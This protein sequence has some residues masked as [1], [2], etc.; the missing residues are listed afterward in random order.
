M[1]D[2]KIETVTPTH[3]CMKNMSSLSSPKL[4]KVTSDIRS[5]LNETNQKNIPTM[6]QPQRSS[7]FGKNSVSDSSLNDGFARL[8]DNVSVGTSPDFIDPLLGDEEK[9]KQAVI[10][11]NVALEKITIHQILEFRQAEE[12]PSP[13]VEHLCLA[14]MQMI[15]QID[16]TVESPVK[17]WA[18]IRKIFHKPGHFVNSLR[19]FQ[20][21][22]DAGRVTTKNRAIPELESFDPEIGRV[23]P[24]AGYLRKWFFGAVGY[25]DATP[26]A[27]A[28]VPKTSVPERQA[29]PKAGRPTSGIPK[30]SVE[31]SSG[32]AVGS[33][34]RPKASC[35][36]GHDDT[37]DA[38]SASDIG[39]KPVR[40]VGSSLGSGYGQNRPNSA[41]APARV[42]PGSS[43]NASSMK[44]KYLESAS[45]RNPKMGNLNTEDINELLEQAKK[46]V[47]ELRSLEAKSR[48]DMERDEKKDVEEKE[49]AE[50][51]DLRVWRWKE[52]DDMKE[53]EDK[54]KQE[55][56][57]T[58]LKD[59]KIYQEAKRDRKK[60]AKEEHLKRIEEQYHDHKKNSKWEAEIKKS[61]FTE[62]QELI[63][64][65]LENFNHDRISHQALENQFKQ[66]QEEKRLMEK[67]STQSLQHKKL[68]EEKEQLLQALKF[69][70]D[71]SQAPLST[72]KVVHERK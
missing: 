10:M 55:N 43:P 42:A 12:P 47:R 54:I 17:T 4:T 13:E 64:N 60:L 44:K 71:R 5:G 3:E 72:R 61:I 8:H 18:E 67:Q 14:L 53:L 59:S 34:L 27:V 6:Q 56:Q 7:L 66:E 35:K 19:R 68:M 39:S 57:I 31:V 45:N 48:W 21:A 28:A 58:E 1:F 30:K 40:T 46:E 26:K 65:N 37:S 16:E 24:L 63:V 41:K 36:K 50:D 29:P 52:Q 38:A 2:F 70:H 25:Y 23:S 32:G 11:M 69:V 20:Y 62:K 22:V 49:K 15:L 9:R 51:E 33:R